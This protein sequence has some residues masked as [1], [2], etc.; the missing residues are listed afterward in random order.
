M[1][2]GF[3]V[4]DNYAGIAEPESPAVFV[5]PE[6]RM[7][8]ERGGLAGDVESGTSSRSNPTQSLVIEYTTAVR[9]ALR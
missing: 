8:E 1:E 7:T 6:P 2:Q 4:D 5:S 9:R 3:L